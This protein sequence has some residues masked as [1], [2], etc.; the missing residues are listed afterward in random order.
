M[1]KKNLHIILQYALLCAR[2]N[3]DSWDWEVGPIHLIKYAYLADLIYA[4][5]HNG[6]TFTGTQWSF[7]NFG[8]WS[9][10]VHREI[11]AALN[12]IGAQMKQLPSDYGD[13][14]Y[15]RWSYLDDDYD[16]LFEEISNK[17]PTSLTFSLQNIVRKFGKD[18]PDLLD[19][20]YNTK[21]MRFASPDEILDFSVVVASKPESDEEF[22]PAMASLTVKK[23][24]KLKARIS[25]IKAAKLKD[26]ASP[27]TRLVSSRMPPI[28]EDV[29]QEGMDWLESLA[30]PP[31]PSGRHEAEF[32][33][34][35]WKSSVRRMEKY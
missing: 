8:P 2:Q 28:D 16:S 19:F 22:V 17:V 7:H 4:E 5:S 33:D 34:S 35:I 13:D 3:E 1:N 26:H 12:A 10:E 23:I 15:Y 9:G 31:L 25:E 27:E 32:D 30:G 21:P 14:D 20:V 24:K 29:Y 6:E 11:P 18:T